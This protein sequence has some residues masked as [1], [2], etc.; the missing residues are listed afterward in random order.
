M[1]FFRWF[2]VAIPLVLM[3]CNEASDP[4]N[5]GKATGCAILDYQNGVQYFS[6]TEAH[7]ANALSQFLA[8]HSDLELAAMA[9]DDTAGRGRSTGYFVVF[10]TIH[11]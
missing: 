4:E 2:L 8:Q 10:R 5:V 3:A 7:F 6:C 11:R 1:K 9:P